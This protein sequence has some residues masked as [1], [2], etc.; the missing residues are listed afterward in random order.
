MNAGDKRVMLVTGASG[1]IGSYFLAEACETYRIIAVA[2]RSQKEARVPPHENITWHQVDIARPADML[3]LAETIER[4]VDKVDFVLHLAG[5]YDFTNEKSPEYQR[6]NVDGTRL[7]LELAKRLEVERLVFSSSITVTE[8]TRSKAPLTERSPADATFPYAVSKRRGEELLRDCSREIPCT[9][10]RL[11][12]VFSDWCEYG[13]L[14]LML[15]DWFG[16][17]TMLGS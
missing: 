9:V 10:V 17:S 7:V 11:A 5:F 6:T 14:Y 2:R 8:F 16:A 12:A 1:F 3:E 4:E 15:S 13:P